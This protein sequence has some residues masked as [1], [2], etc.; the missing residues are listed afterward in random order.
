MIVNRLLTLGSSRLRYALLPPT[1][2]DLDP[3]PAPRSVTLLSDQTL[4]HGIGGREALLRLKQIPGKEFKLKKGDAVARGQLLEL[5]DKGHAVISPISGTVTNMTPYVGDYGRVYMT[6]TIEAGETDAP[7]QTESFQRSDMF[8]AAPALPGKPDLPKTPPLR[9]IINGLGSDVLATNNQY[10][11]KTRQKDLEAGLE[12]IRSTWPSASAHLMV[13]EGQ[14]QEWNRLKGCRVHGV[15]PVYPAAS[16]RLLHRTVTGEEAPSEASLIEAGTLVLQAEALAAMGSLYATGI[17]P[18]QKLVQVMGKDGI[19]HLISVCIGTPVS[20][21][22][23]HLGLK[24]EYGDRLILG[25]PMTGYAVYTD[26]FPVCPDT[27]TLLVQAAEKGVP[28]QTPSCINCGAC[29]RICPARVPVNLLLRVLEA[30]HYGEAAESF[31]LM[32]CI[33]CGLCSFVCPGRIPIFQYIQLAKYEH[34]RQVA[35]EAQNQ[36]VAE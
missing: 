14:Q 22:L 5:F 1:P 30:G 3:L 15:A 29:N 2:P 20:K 31:D 32:S 8:R 27:D 28:S 4:G 24:A 19:G 23:E 11:L 33:D 26:D 16:P 13:V 9:V 18:M 7:P 36:E 21:V 6:L 17:P 10:V 34:R 12:W 25:G 35:E